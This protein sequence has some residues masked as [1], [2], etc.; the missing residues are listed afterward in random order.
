MSSPILPPILPSTLGEAQSLLQDLAQRWPQQHAALSASKPL[1]QNALETVDPQWAQVF[2]AS[3]NWLDEVPLVLLSASKSVASKQAIG[4]YAKIAASLNLVLKEASSPAS[5]MPGVSALFGDKKLSPPAFLEALMGEKKALDEASSVR[6]NAMQ[7]A[8]DLGDDARLLAA[9]LSDVMPLLRNRI[10]HQRE[11]VDIEG[12]PS[13]LEAQR[14]A[15]EI[16]NLDRAL[17]ALELVESRIQN[18]TA[19]EASINRSGLEHMVNQEQQMSARLN[20]LSTQITKTIAGE[21]VKTQSAQQSARLSQ[22]A[23]VATPAAPQELPASVSMVVSQ[24]KRPGFF[25]RLFSRPKQELLAIPARPEPPPAPPVKFSSATQELLDNID[26]KYTNHPILIWR[27]FKLVVQDHDVRAST[28]L[29]KSKCSLLDKILLPRVW[30]DGHRPSHVLNMMEDLLKR[31]PRIKHD[32]CD[33][34]VLSSVCIKQIETIYHS[35]ESQVWASLRLISQMRDFMDMT[36]HAPALAKFA[37]SFAF[38]I[39]EDSINYPALLNVLDTMVPPQSIKDAAEQSWESH[40]DRSAANLAVFCKRS[41]NPAVASALAFCAIKHNELS[42]RNAEREK[43]LMELLSPQDRQDL[44]K[45]LLVREPSISTRAKSKN[46]LATPTLISDLAAPPVAETQW[47]FALR[48]WMSLEQSELK[49]RPIPSRLLASALSMRDYPFLSRVVSLCASKTLEGELL[50]VDGTYQAPL[51]LVMELDRE[52]KKTLEFR[53]T[54]DYWCALFKGQLDRTTAQTYEEPPG[55]RGRITGLIEKD[56]GI[57]HH[58][59]LPSTRPMEMTPLMQA[60]N[61]GDYP[62]VRALLSAGANPSISIDGYDALSLLK[63]HVIKGIMLHE[64]NPVDIGNAPRKTQDVFIRRMVHAMNETGLWD[65]QKVSPPGCA[66]RMLLAAM[67]TDLTSTSKRTAEARQK[68]IHQC[69]NAMGVST[70]VESIAG[71]IV[72][73]GSFTLDSKE[74]STFIDHGVSAGIIEKDPAARASVMEE[75]NQRLS[76]LNAAAV[77]PRARGIRVIKI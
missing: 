5:K 30:E 68:G 53:Q 20:I 36:P 31:E 46:L 64:D 56:E 45:H 15:R 61:Q 62:W 58:A 32:L 42:V 11:R 28:M 14:R 1:W 54:P 9:I 18:E 67:S 52:F 44:I 48:E 22:I 55:V 74:V 19:P 3:V 50:H 35:G 71:S 66:Q 17:T 47:S 13:M 57:M 26:D 23:V 29:S 65:I 25:S 73:R 41:K 60:A 63:T 70:F 8:L 75:I 43:E 24:P 40:L 6:L 37:L 12:A 39:K 27:D 77:A 21:Q 76:Q 7:D 69:I 59:R 16:K 72:P 34:K 2:G 49:P 33:W 51:S 4:E 10:Q 38:R